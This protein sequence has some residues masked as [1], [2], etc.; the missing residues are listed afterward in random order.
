MVSRGYEFFDR[1]S[2]RFNRFTVMH[3][4]G[5]HPF[6]FNDDIFTSTKPIFYSFDW[7]WLEEAYIMGTEQCKST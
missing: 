4:V 5:G 3:S 2:G 1:F 7:A 6:T